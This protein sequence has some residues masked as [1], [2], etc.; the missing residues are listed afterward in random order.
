[1]DC[2]RNLDYIAGFA[3]EPKNFKDVC[4]GCMLVSEIH[5]YVELYFSSGFLG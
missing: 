1:M 2:H 3:L 4:K 5:L